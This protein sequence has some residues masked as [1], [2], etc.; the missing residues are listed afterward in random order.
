M[1]PFDVQKEL[2]KSRSWSSFHNLFLCNSSSGIHASPDYYGK[3]R[4]HNTICSEISW[5]VWICS[6]S[7]ATHIS[8]RSHFLLRESNT[9]NKQ[10]ALHFRMTWRAWSC[11][12]AE[13]P[14]ST[15]AS[16]LLPI[17]SLRCRIWTDLS[18]QNLNT[19]DPRERNS[20]GCIFPDRFSKSPS[21]W[22]QHFEH[23]AA[24]DSPAWVSLFLRSS[25][26]QIFALKNK[27][28]LNKS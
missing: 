17:H 21:I 6:C 27:E 10:F 2:W 20:L 8:P 19:T 25:R 1:V 22:V 7:S 3:C 13:P 23:D 16:H 11:V 24:L 18:C 26:M 4:V 15:S 14:D 9:S 28:Q 12:V 5:Q